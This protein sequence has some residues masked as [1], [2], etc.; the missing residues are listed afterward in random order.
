MLPGSAPYYDGYTARI[1]EAVSKFN[2]GSG[3][4]YM[5]WPKIFKEASTDFERIICLVKVLQ[6]SVMGRICDL[7][8]SE[9]I[10]N[11]NS[12]YFIYFR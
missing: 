1:R 9:S 3:D 7:L 4:R 12:C 8:L 2:V 11:S 10:T 6:N 5:A